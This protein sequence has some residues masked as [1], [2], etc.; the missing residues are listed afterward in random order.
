MGWS[1]EWDR[2]KNEDIIRRTGMGCMQVMVTKQQIWFTGDMLQLPQERL[3]IAMV[4]MLRGK[5]IEWKTKE[6]VVQYIQGQHHNHY[7]YGWVPIR[8]TTKLTHHTSQFMISA[9]RLLDA[10]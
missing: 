7:Y 4:W 2:V 10:F 1:E 3:V 9:S 8:A 6:D 5:K